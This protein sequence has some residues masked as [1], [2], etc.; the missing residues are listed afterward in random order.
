VTDLVL[1]A[2]T[3]MQSGVCIGGT[4]PLSRDHPPHWVRPVKPFGTLMPDDIRLP[5]GGLMQPWDIVALQLGRARSQPPH[6]EDVETDFVRARPALRG[7]L[8]EPERRAILE[9]LTEP[10][11]ERLWREQQRSLTVFSPPALAATFSW[12]PYSEHYDARLWWPGCGRS[13]GL[14]VTDLKWRALGRQLTAA[15]PAERHLDTAELRG[16]L[17][18]EEIFVAAG[19]SRAFHGDYWPLVVAVHTFPDYD[20]TVDE[21]HL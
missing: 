17:G 6:V 12:D 7:R 20:A 16:Q 14:P 1:L 11:P 4:P 21:K 9:R 5:H 15:G 2:V 18:C 13:D 8:P 19:L 10:E 3:R